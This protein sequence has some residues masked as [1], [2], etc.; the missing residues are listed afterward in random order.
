MDNEAEPHSELVALLIYANEWQTN[1]ILGRLACLIEA[2]PEMTIRQFLTEAKANI[3]SDPR[4][5]P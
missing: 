2:N 4:Q 5:K 1:R 3:E